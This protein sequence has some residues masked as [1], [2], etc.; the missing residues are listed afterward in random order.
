MHAEIIAI[1][2][3]IVSGG[4]ADTNSQWLSQKLE[5]LGVRVLYHSTVG[6]ELAPCVDVFRMAIERADIVI[7]TGGLG[8]TA[9]DLTRQALAEAAGLEL[10]LYPQA[11]EHIRA[12]FAGRKRPMPP[13][14]E[15]QAMF[16]AGSRMID[17]PH[18]TAPGIDLEVPRPGRSS[19]RF[20]AL[21]G[22]PAEMVEMWNSTLSA[23]IAPLAA[24]QKV[25]RRRKI[26][27]F[28]AGESQVEAMLPDLIRRG[29][30]PT[31]GITASKTTISLRITAEAATEEECN[32]L[33]EP[34]AATIRQC[35]GNLVFG[36]D[37][38]ELQHVVARLLGQRGKT[39]ATVE[40]GTAGLI[41]DWLGDL[42]DG[43][44][45][46]LG[47]LVL[48]SQDSMA[49]LLGLDRTLMPDQSARS[50]EASERMAAACRERLAADYSLAVGPFPAFAP[51]TSQPVHLALADA[52]GVKTKAIPYAGHPAWLKIYIAK[53]AL[54]LLRLDLADASAS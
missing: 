13:Q 28:G 53:H 17:N 39:L 18:G 26:N 32:A 44:D 8:P 23:E 25:I 15:I 31:V 47:G 40:W 7:A 41:A 22:V 3:E 24:G 45:W 48:R 14:N 38:E 29:R 2:D 11:I 54:N 9:D 16:P 6:D 49:R 35:L 1:G 46:F 21:P 34:T 51:Q 19:C 30:A 5:E 43:G 36:E 27:C 20:F 42:A 50:R 4:H 37:D 12:L 33:I 10:V 52:Q